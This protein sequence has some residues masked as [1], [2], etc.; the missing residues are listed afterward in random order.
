M[1]ALTKLLCLTMEIPLS[2]VYSILDQAGDASDYWARIEVM[3]RTGIDEHGHAAARVIHVEEYGDESTMVSSATLAVDEIVT[4]LRRVLTNDMVKDGVPIRVPHAL[5]S[6][7]TR[8]DLFKALCDPENGALNMDIWTVDAVI[9]A[10]ALG[11][12][13]YG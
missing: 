4:G 10:S 11:R 2:L 5:C 1:T 8:A 12:I 3:S 7:N 6:E 9:Q 13:V